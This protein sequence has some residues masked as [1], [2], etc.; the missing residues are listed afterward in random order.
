MVERER[1]KGRSKDIILKWKDMSLFKREGV[2]KGLIILPFKVKYR[3]KGHDW[4]GWGYIGGGAEGLFLFPEIFDC[5]DKRVANS[6][7]SFTP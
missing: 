6:Q 1:E 3:L 5:S 7:L 4:R 2:N